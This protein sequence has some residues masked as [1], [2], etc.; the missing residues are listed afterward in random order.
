MPILIGTRSHVADL[1]EVHRLSPRAQVL[2]ST[3]TP[4]ICILPLLQAL[5]YM[6][7]QGRFQPR[8]P[9]IV[10]DEGLVVHAGLALLAPLERSHH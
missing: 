4:Q 5:L 9:N 2:G 8:G 6:T 1:Q 7:V 3:E 10:E